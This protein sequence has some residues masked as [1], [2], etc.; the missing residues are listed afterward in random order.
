MFFDDEDTEDEALKPDPVID[1]N[2]IGEDGIR[3]G[4]GTDPIEHNVS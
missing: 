2:D 4:E 1:A 3:I